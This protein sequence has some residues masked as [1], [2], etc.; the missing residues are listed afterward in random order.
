MNV[1]PFGQWIYDDCTGRIF[2]I[3][4]SDGKRLERTILLAIDILIIDQSGQNV[5]LIVNPTIKRHSAVII[6]PPISKGTE[7]SGH[8]LA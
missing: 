5:I 3:V 1:V 8:E 7:R 2:F 6:N 4:G